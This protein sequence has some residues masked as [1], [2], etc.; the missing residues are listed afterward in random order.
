MIS[1]SKGSHRVSGA[2]RLGS[3]PERHASRP[4]PARRRPRKPTR[5]RKAPPSFPSRDLEQPERWDG[6]E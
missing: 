6:M 1:H 3:A 2:Q 4:E 5:P